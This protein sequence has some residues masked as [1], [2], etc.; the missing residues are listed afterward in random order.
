MTETTSG[1][2]RF[3]GTA[4]AG[5]NTGVTV[6][7]VGIGVQVDSALGGGISRTHAG[8]FAAG[9]PA[10]ARNIIAWA[11]SAGALENVV[12]ANKAGNPSTPPTS[13]CTYGSAASGAGRP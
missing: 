1:S 4:T 7:G 5:L 6:F 2:Y 3:N 8:D 12:I 9:T 13:A 11:A 10:T